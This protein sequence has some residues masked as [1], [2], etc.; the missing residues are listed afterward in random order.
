MNI[1]DIK[2]KQREFENKI[3]KPEDRPPIDWTYYLDSS[4]FIRSVLA[5]SKYGEEIST[6]D[7][8]EVREFCRKHDLHS[9]TDIIQFAIDNTEF[10]INGLFGL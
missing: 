8:Y 9:D 5:P 7:D 10:T 6:Y 4:N 3:N 1:N 2:K